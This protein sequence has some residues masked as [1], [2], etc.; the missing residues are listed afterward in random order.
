MFDTHLA[1]A[2]HVANLIKL[3][4]LNCIISAQYTITSVQATKTC[5]CFHDWTTVIPSS[6]DV[7][8]TF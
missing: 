2:A 8:C 4:N 3:L 1:V 7:F 5:F 6:L